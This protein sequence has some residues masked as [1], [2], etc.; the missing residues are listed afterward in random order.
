M[1]FYPS[2]SRSYSRPKIGRIRKRI[3]IYP[4]LIIFFIAIVFIYGRYLLST[5]KAETSAVLI[6]T[7]AENQTSS[8]MIVTPMQEPKPQPE[9]ILPEIALENTSQS[10][11]DAA[12]CINEVTL[13]INTKPDSI[14]EARDKLNQS[15][16]ISMSREQQTAIKL[17]LSELADKWLFSRTI[18]PQDKLCSDYIVKPGDLLK[19]IGEQHKVPW[20]ILKEINRINQPEM[21]Q[22]AETIKVI[23]GP[24][25]VKIYRSTFTMDLYLQ[26]T[27]VKSF[28]VGLG[29]SG[30]ET[31]KGLWIVKPGG[32]MIS[33]PWTDPDTSKRYEA[34]NPNYPLGSRWIALE[35]VEG[36]AKGRVGFAIHGTKKPE[37]IGTADSRGCIRLRDNDVILMYNLLMPGFSR[38]Q[39]L[40]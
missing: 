28:P 19:R 36:E 2:R 31:P 12:Q 17:K 22:A 11:P 3:H 10:N 34:D 23:H 9:I 5:N 39:V 32:K 13:L 27:F 33:P 25:H 15:L 20:E 37:Q 18:F 16:S 4:V 6:D 8:L 24:F 35:G 26:D 40:E 7:E 38:V 1:A 14:I 29:K 21:L 30:R